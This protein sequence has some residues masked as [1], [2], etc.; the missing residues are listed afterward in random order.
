MVQLGF[1]TTRG[2]LISIVCIVLGMPAFM[3]HIMKE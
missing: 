3:F 2:V 1:Y